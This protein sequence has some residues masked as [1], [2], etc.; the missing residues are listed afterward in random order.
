[1]TESGL[2]VWLCWLLA[3]R[4]DIMPIF[5]LL[6][7]FFFVK[8]ALDMAARS[9]GLSSGRSFLASGPSSSALVRSK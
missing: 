3:A 5:L 6:L 4:A 1:M 2:F 9:E 8:W 7:L